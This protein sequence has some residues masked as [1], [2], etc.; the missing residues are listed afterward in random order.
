MLDEEICKLK[1]E[2]TK[3]GR[4]NA[5]VRGVDLAGPPTILEQFVTLLSWLRLHP[6]K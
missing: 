1:I 3:M 6:T 5:R 4:V 2:V